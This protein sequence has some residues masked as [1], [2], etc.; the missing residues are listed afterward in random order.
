MG[1]KVNPYGFRLGITTDW[2]SRWY[3]DREQY[4]DYVVEDWEIRRYLMSRMANAAISRIEVERTRDRVRIDLHTARPGIV[5]GRR[6][7]MADE[8][9]QELARITDNP[10]VQLNIQEIKQPELDAALIA[11]GVADQLANRMAFRRAMK[12][13]VQNAMKAGALG[14][15]VQCGGRLGGAEMSRSEWY[16]EGRVPLHTLRADIDYGLREAATSTGQVGVKVWLYKGDILPYKAQGEDKASKEAAMAVGESTG[17]EATPRV[18]SSRPTPPNAG[19]AADEGT[20]EPAPLLKE[21]DPEFEKLLTEEEEIER[22]AQSR[23][24][25]PEHFRPNEGE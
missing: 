2:K 23:S 21:A 7:A 1:Q 8:L 14:I 3:A 20:E 22:Q 6:G 4:V 17:Q 10:K 9:R 19:D 5:I 16:R 18:V 25:G 24:K 13:A 12:R 15:R 11:Q